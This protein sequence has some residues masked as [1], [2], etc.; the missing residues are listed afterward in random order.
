MRSRLWYNRA[1]NLHGK[2]YDYSETVHMNDN[3]KVTII[4]KKHGI[5]KQFMRH[6]LQGSG[7]P[8]CSSIS[9]ANKLSLTK[10]DFIKRANRIHNKKYDYSIFKYINAKT[11]GIIICPNHGKFKQEAWGHMSGNGCSK[12]SNNGTSKI[13]QEWIDLLLI[14][15]PKLR[16]FYHDNGE[17]KIP[18]TN[19]KADGYNKE[20]KTIYEFHGDFWHGN[21]K[22]YKSDEFNE[23]AKKTF[24]EL[25][26]NTKKKQKECEDM[27]YKYISIW[28]N[29]WLKGKMAL[30]RIQNNFRKKRMEKKFQYNCEK[31]NYKTNYKS[32]YNRHCNTELHKTGKR[33]AKKNKVSYICQICKLY[34]GSCNTNLKNHILIN[35]KTK[36]DREKEFPNYCKICDYGTFSKKMFDNHLKTKKH[37]KKK[38]M[39]DKLKNSE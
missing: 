30:K 28:E 16:H 31:C 37:T 21:P 18:K 3:K 1:I 24:G 39:V 20:T 9:T 23:I 36:E 33:G 35:H 26:E 5:F 11:K 17:F 8:K 34:E 14:K 25:H 32:H 22:K 38:K 10:S 29:D 2:R 12:C 19:Y 4:C 13:A 27:G 15:Q 7:C 6:H